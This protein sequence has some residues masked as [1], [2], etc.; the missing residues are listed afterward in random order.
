MSMKV[1]KNSKGPVN[2]EREVVKRELRNWGQAA[3]NLRELPN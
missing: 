3:S 2:E 1:E